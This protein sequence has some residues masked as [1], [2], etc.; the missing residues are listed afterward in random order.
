MLSQVNV[1]DIL[2]IDIETVPQHPNFD[3]LDEVFQGLWEK[4]STFFR[5]EEQT[6]ADV[7]E[8]AGI[9]AEFGKII[10]ISAGVVTQR[11]GE[12]VYRVK[13]FYDDNEKKL[14]AQFNDM[15]NKFMSHSGKRVCAHNGQEFDYPYIARRTLINGLPLPKALDIAGMKPWEV[16]DKLMDT[17]QLWK[18]GDYKNYTSL[19]L[20]CAVFNIPTPKDDIDGSQVAQVYYED[21]E[22]DRVIRYCEK[23]TL[24]VAN[25]LLRY[26]GEP[27]I[28]MENIQVV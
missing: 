26:K 24:A 4:K 3:E 16:K 14:L 11:L 20:L 21:G 27:I 1:E 10:C 23:D 5:N 22:I 6:P 12:R 25:L 18:F 17:L 2:F 28:P 9:Y 7:Y 15:L 13:S 19:N 8:R